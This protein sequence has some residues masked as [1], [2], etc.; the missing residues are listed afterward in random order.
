MRDR[1][2]ASLLN[3]SLILLVVDV[4]KTLG[5]NLLL[6]SVHVDVSNGGVAVEDT[7]DLLESGTLGLGVDE[8]HKDKLDR[9]PE[10]C[11]C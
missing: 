2:D 4:V 10:L 11:D 7:G 5:L 8:V 6:N 9:D 3:A 1:L